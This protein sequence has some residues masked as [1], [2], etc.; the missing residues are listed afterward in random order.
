MQTDLWWCQGRCASS[1]SSSPALWE[2]ADEKH[3]G[4]TLHVAP[5]SSAEQLHAAWVCSGMQ[6]LFCAPSCKPLQRAGVC[7]NISAGSSLMTKTYK[8]SQRSTFKKTAPQQLTKFQENLPLHSHPALK[9]KS[10]E[11]KNLKKNTC[12][13]VCVCA[14]T[15]AYTHC[16]LAVSL[17]SYINSRQSGLTDIVSHE[18]VGV[19]GFWH[20]QGASS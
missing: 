9:N 10:K 14:R 13:S 8:N 17:H 6:I 1:S 2:L 16:V 12:C 11:D 3:G 4:F 5:C 7:I 19:A 18:T 20:G 15:H